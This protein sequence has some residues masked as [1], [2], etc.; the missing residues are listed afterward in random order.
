M[1]S[2]IVKAGCLQFS[3]YFMN[4]P[5]LNMPSHGYKCPDSLEQDPML[6]MIDML[7][8]LLSIKLIKAES[9]F[10][11]FRFSQIN[12]DEVKKMYQNL[13]PKK[14]SQKDDIEINLL[15]NNIIFCK[16]SIWW[17]QWFN[18]FLKVS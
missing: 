5:I 2:S 16:V 1:K 6:K 9:N 15:R 4:I 10:Q 13:D 11:I 8:D 14:I 7:W 12:I 3:E 18:S 17:Y